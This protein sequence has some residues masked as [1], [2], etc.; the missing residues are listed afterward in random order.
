MDFFNEKLK[1]KILSHN[2][3]QLKLLKV[4]DQNI[5]IF[6]DSQYGQGIVMQ[7]E[8]PN[9]MM[10]SSVIKGPLLEKYWENKVDNLFLDTMLSKLSGKLL[11]H[12]ILLWAKEDLLEKTNAMIEFLNNWEI[13]ND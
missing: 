10:K 8:N 2:S 9:P 12:N 13:E 1:S 5:S 3:E 6:L 11:M 7:S 4:M